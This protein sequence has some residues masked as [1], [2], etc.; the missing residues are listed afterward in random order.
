MHG[1]ARHLLLVQRQLDRHAFVH[2][3][4]Q[5]RAPD[6]AD[7]IAAQ[8]TDAD[9]LRQRGIE[10]L[11]V[12]HLFADEFDVEGGHVVRQHHAVTVEDQARGWAGSARCGCCCPARDSCNSRT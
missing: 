9:Q 4:Q 10:R 11:G 3:V 7:L 2:L 8:Q 1:E 5:N 12:A 6:V